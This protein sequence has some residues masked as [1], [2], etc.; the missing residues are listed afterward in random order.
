M[1]NND[2]IK[3]KLLEYWLQSEQGKHVRLTE[4]RRAVE[5]KAQGNIA[6]AGIFIAVSFTWIKDV[7]EKSITLNCF[8]AMGLVMATTLFL[9]SVLVSVFVLFI[10]SIPVP[11]D[12]ALVEQIL[13]R[14]DKGLSNGLHPLL[15]DL[16]RHLK[17]VND[18]LEKFNKKKSYWLFIA[19]VFLSLG[20]C[21]I[22]LIAIALVIQ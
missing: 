12:D 3:T 9:L 8:E 18:R 2:S 20:I 19:Q 7:V 5:N 6:I 16:S 21:L 13:D 17:D 1:F 22:A 14:G 11:S 4:N 10:E 15:S